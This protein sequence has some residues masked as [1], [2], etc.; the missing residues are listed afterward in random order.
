[1]KKAQG[2]SMNTII[3]AA[4]AL[5]VLVILSI[6][7]MGRMGWFTQSSSDCN[8]VGGTCMYSQCKDA[9]D[10][11]GNQVYKEHPSAKCYTTGTT[12]V[13]PNLHCCIKIQ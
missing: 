8:K 7:F 10:T 12:E 6:I 4:I 2:L 13:D 11:A 1:M 3:I 9:Q 5:L